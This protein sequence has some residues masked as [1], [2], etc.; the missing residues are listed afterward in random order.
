VDVADTFLVDTCLGL[1]ELVELSLSLGK[2]TE[3]FSAGR[4]EGNLVRFLEGS[5]L[6]GGSGRVRVLRRGA[7]GGD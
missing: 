7:G 4:S 6:G 2:G 5:V 3:S 1:V